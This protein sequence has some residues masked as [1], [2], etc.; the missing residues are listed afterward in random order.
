MTTS[1]QPADPRARRRAIVLLIIAVAGGTL[2]ISA[3]EGGTGRF[4]E[5]L[6]Q[7]PSRLRRWVPVVLIGTMG[8]VLLPLGATAAYL[9]WLSI[10]TES[11]VSPT[12]LAT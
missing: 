9:A 10:R 1:I 8:L 2:V 4:V 6:G 12:L 3:A 11:L 7:D 5:W